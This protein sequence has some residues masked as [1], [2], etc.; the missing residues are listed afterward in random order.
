MALAE[1]LGLRRVSLRSES[2]RWDFHT[3]EA[4]FGFCNAGFGA[5]TQRLPEE[6]RRAFVEETMGRY[7]AMI[8]AAFGE[9]FVFHFMQT[10]M[11]LAPT[12]GE[13]SVD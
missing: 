8:D 11:V 10:D 13:A 1:S 12:G 7:L 2:K 5:W 3:E 4:F 9:R 6:R